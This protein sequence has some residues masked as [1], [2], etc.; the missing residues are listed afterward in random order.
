VIAVGASLSGY[1]THLGKLYPK[2]QVIRI[3]REERAVRHHRV[4]AGAHLICDAKEGVA[5]INEVLAR[6]G[7]AKSGYRTKAVAERIRESKE[8]REQAVAAGTID[9]RSALREINRVVPRDWFIV[10]GS[11]HCA[12]FTATEMRNRPPELY[13][14]IRDFGAIGSNLA[15]AI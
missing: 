12:Y 9:P 11:G 14:S 6:S 10:G 4:L 5:A 2:A 1:T 7:P 15:H 8:P 13:A 3:D